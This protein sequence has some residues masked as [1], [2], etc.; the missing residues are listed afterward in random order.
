MVYI[1]YVTYIALEE[2][3]G[4]LKQLHDYIKFS[5]IFALTYVA[6]FFAT[7]DLQN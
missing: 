6:L 2:C 1:A 4:Q 5:K 7:D 3:S